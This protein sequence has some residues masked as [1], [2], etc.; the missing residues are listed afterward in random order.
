MTVKSGTI[1][2]SKTTSSPVAMKLRLLLWLAFS[3][4]YGAV[5]PTAERAPGTTA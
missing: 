2:Y 4:V 5:A 3:W 1:K